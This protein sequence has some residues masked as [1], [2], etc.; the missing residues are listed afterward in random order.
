M[1]LDTGI[2]IIHCHGCHWVTAHKYAPSVDVVRIYDSLYNTADDIVKTVTK[3]L[4]GGSVR[5]EMVAHM[6]KQQSHSNN[7]G[8]FAIAIATAILF[9]SNL[10]KLSFKEEEMREHLVCCFERAAITLFPAT[11]M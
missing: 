11:S 5:V 7:C 8:L 1:K 2:Q 9:K 3:N 10:E 4:F 6:Q